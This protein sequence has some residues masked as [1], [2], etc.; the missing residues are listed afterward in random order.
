MKTLNDL[1]R[2]YY[3][4]LVGANRDFEKQIDFFDKLFKK[5]NVK[6]VLD[7]GCGTGT[8]AV[9]LA[10]RGYVVSAFDYSKRMVA[11]AKKKARENNVH[12]NFF[13]A[14]IRDFN[15]GRFDAVISLYA[16]IMFGCKSNVDLTN[17]VK[18]IKNALNPN[19]I[20]FIETMTS[21]MLEGSG[22]E[23][24]KYVDKKDK[25]VRLSF[26]T[27]N[28][29]KKSAKLHY[30]EI[31][32]K[33]NKL[34]YRES[35]ASHYYFDKVDFDSAFKNSRARVISWYSSF[36]DKKRKYDHFKDKQSWM[37]SPLFH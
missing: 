10:K 33:E 25:V 27:F 30:V 5:Y 14:D 7:C 24:N 16:P 32:Q 19:G 3:D 29:K 12:V 15:L 26:Y 6:T 28:H 23:I 2:I 21:K 18:S 13:V 22:L 8:H 20:A 35:K 37:I 17:A 34:S 1:N 9:L 4:K 31:L 11:L 36:N